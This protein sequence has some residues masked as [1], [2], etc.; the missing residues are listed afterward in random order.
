MNKKVS[1]GVRKLE[2]AS[3]ADRVS[4]A[5]GDA[6]T[7]PFIN[8][9]FD[10]VFMSF[11]LELFDAPEIPVVLSEGKRVLKTGG[12]FCVVGLSQD[13]VCRVFTVQPH[14]E[15]SGVSIIFGTKPFEGVSIIVIVRLRL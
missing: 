5:C 4:L 10:L 11:S 6:A 2:K 8:E 1:R 15:S 9:S 13:Q 7:L 3:A 12:V 14:G